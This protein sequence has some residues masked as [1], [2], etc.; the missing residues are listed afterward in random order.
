MIQPASGGNPPRAL[1]TLS[2]KAGVG[3]TTTAI[4]LDKALHRRGI[5]VVICRATTRSI[6]QY[7]YPRAEPL[8]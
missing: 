3:K 2:M 7:L 6:V 1:L 5:K 4:G 8:K